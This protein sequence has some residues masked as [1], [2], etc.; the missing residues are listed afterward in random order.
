MTLI[1]FIIILSV[2]IFIH[3]LGHFIFAKRAGIYVYEFCI[4]M[5]PRIFK[6]KRKNDE[7]EYGIRLFPIGGFCSMAGESNEIDPNVESSKLLQNKTWLDRFLTIIAGVTFNFLLALILLFIFGLIN[8]N[9]MNKPVI[10]KYSGELHENDLI[11]K[12]D[13]K[14]VANTDMFLILYQ[15]NYGKTLNL[16]VLRDSNE[17][18][19]KIDPKIED[20]NYN[21]GITLKQ[22]VKYGF[23]EA[24]KYSLS[25]FA[26]LVTQLFVTIF[27]LFTGK[28]SLTNL[29][30]PIGI[31][32]VVGQYSKMGFDQ[33]IF[34][35]G[36]LSLN[37]GFMNLLPLPAFDGGRLLFLILEKI[38][39][40]KL[41]SKIE[42]TIHSIGFLL[43]MI[44]MLYITYNDILRFIIKS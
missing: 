32:N 35:T 15:V 27:Y 22:E 39:R 8:G 23:I 30:G 19:I 5:G 3:E 20:N 28:L 33:L 34:L 12:V 17:V 31:Y 11:I 42:N 13:N 10:N 16:T 24:I 41:D 26:S 2:T 43:L 6:F 36:Y 21:Y 40:R 44:L 38:F 18:N 14:K 1:Y 9:P 25:K 7:T 29:S 37:V 4:G